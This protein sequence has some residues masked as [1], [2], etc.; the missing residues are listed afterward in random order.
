VRHTFRATL[1]ALPLA[2]LVSLAPAVPAQAQ[3]VENYQRQARTV[4]NNVRENHDRVRLRQGR[5][6]QRF[7]R[8]QARRMANQER[9]FHQD[10]GPVMRQC[11]LSS[12][13][14]NV[15]YG[16]PTG[17]RVVR[18]W[19]RSPGHRANILTKSYRLLGLAMRR[20]DNGTPYAVQVFG[21]R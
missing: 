4:T 15:A 14:E 6:V 16:Y 7:A 5:C 18:A 2:L 1:A 11:N 17:R 20:S 3:S 19:M 9:M 10:L 13:G 12:V 8:R 21:R